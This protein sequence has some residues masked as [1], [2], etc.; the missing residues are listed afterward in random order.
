MRARRYGTAPPRGVCRWSATA[1]IV[2]F[3]L[4]ANPSS[5]AT[6][7]ICRTLGTAD[8]TARLVIPAGSLFRDNGRADDPLVAFTGDRWRLRLETIVQVEIPELRPCVWVQVRVTSDL[9]VKSV[10]MA[11]NRT[12]L[13]AGSSDLIDP[14]DE[15]EALFSTKGRVIDQVP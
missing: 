9:S 7:E 12:F 10:S 15:S 4:M 13:Y 14:P 2:G 1:L 11:D 3:V 6:F 5:A 8:L